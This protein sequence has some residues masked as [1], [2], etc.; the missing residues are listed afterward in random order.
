MQNLNMNLPT[1]KEIEV[2]IFR[3]LQEQY[4]KIMVKYLE[5]LDE[6]IMESRDK[7]RFRMH[8]RR[9]VSLSTS[10]GE[11]T[12]TR[13]MYQDRYTQKYVYLLDRL[14]SFEG[15][16]GVSPHLEELAIE[17]ASRGPSYREAAEQIEQ[18]LGYPAMSHETIR[19]KLLEWNEKEIPKP[20]NKRKPQVLFVETD[21]LFTHLQGGKRRNKEN[22]IAVVHE[23][24]GRTGRR[25]RLQHKRHYLHTTKEPFWEGFGEFLIDHYDVDEDTWLVVNGDGASW[26]SECTSYF[27][28][29]IF[30]LDR[31]H[32]YRDLRGFLK[33]H[34]SIW[35]QA[36]K[37][38]DTYNPEKLLTILSG[39]SID[40]IAEERQ[41][42]WKDYKDFL[43]RHQEHLRDYR[44]RLRKE[45][46]DTTDMRP[47]GSAESQMN[48]VARRTKG[49]Y[50][51][52]VLGVQAMIRSIMARKEGTLHDARMT[53]N[54]LKDKKKKSPF[55]L[56]QLFKKSQEDSSS[57][58]DAS[59]QYLK[60]ANQSSPL[61]MALKGLRGS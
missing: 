46:F 49:G 26:I 10:F 6:W 3:K 34:P 31:F 38:L 58:L 40:L 4:I 15:H 25:V 51:W 55:K 21:G 37:A 44:K 13:R 53:E 47:M 11:V 33:E 32:V 60:T 12:F 9:K 29:C 61:G 35:S 16:E 39:I 43:Y 7:D 41:E 2:T 59:I 24:W 50:S 20:K 45:G 54:K 19:K 1:L 22:R 5:K 27:H 23:G 36:K 30:T 42:K 52:S 17:L 8:D 18:F 14:M 28:Q 57:Y 56:G 48:V